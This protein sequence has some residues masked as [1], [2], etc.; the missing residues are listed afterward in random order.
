MGKNYLILVLFVFTLVFTTVTDLAFL[1]V[2][3]PPL[4]PFAVLP[5][6]PIPLAEAP[7]LPPLAV[8]PPVEETVT[9]LF[10]T[11]A[12]LV[13]VTV[14]SPLQQFGSGQH[15]SLFTTNL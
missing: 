1:V 12:L 14:T 2:T 4:P 15:S 10:T 5:L 7:A 6:L 3:L 11:T 13:L 8:L 9:T